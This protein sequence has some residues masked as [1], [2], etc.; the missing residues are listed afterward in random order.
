M[1]RPERDS[2]FG[3]PQIRLEGREGFT[4]KVPVCFSS[5]LMF[6]IKRRRPMPQLQ[7]ACAF[8][9]PPTSARRDRLRY[10]NGNRIN[11]SFARRAERI[12]PHSF[13]AI[14]ISAFA[15]ARATDQQPDTECCCSICSWRMPGRATPQHFVRQNHRAPRHAHKLSPARPRPFRSSR[16][17][18]LARNPSSGARLE[19]RKHA[20]EEVYLSEVCKGRGL[21]V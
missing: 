3:Q 8:L 14:N 17:Q 13:P 16:A 6:A 1:I 7:S 9:Y 19:H 10:G 4:G 5:R 12:L 20:M 2:I 21:F 15:S 18:P 11:G